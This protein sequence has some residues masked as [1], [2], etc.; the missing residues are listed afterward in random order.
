M[1]VNNSTNINERKELALA[2]NIIQETESQF[3]EIKE[4]YVE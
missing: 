1:M 3:S 4:K 2:R